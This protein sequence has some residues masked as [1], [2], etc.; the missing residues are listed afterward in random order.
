[1]KSIRSK[2]LLSYLVVLLV[3]VAVTLL[4]VSFTSR[5]AYNRQMGALGMH[6]GQELQPQPQQRAQMQFAN[7]RAA[8]FESLGYAALAAS[9]AAVLV[10]LFLSERIVLPLRAMTQASQRIAEGHYDER[11]KVS[12]DDEL[13]ELAGRFNQMAEQLEQTES[14]R[15]RLIGDVA[16]ELRTPLTTIKG[17]M[18]GLLDGV[19][20]PDQETFTQI[21][22]ESERLGRLVDDLQE[23]SR[24]EAGAYTLDKQ[25]VDAAAL[26]ATA[27]KRLQ[28][29]LDAKRIDLT[30]N[31]PTDLP[32]LLADEDRIL[33]VLTNL[34]NNALQYTP[35]KGTVNIQ[36]QK[37]AEFVQFS[38]HDT[39]AGIAPENLDLIFSRFYRVDKSRSR[40]AGSGSGIG[41]TIAKHLVEAHGGRIWVESPGL[42]QGSTFSFT[43]PQSR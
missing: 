1:M 38:V 35:T 36:A 2:L 5:L 17:S 43:I 22:E 11:V 31:L 24:V 16:H 37:N 13:A 28:R 9:L 42:G 33:Q 6:M 7:F 34:L 14:M 3:G 25:P 40:Q 8:V 41:L 4:S 30:L 15:R 29:Q 10:S 21:L 39:G 18:E 12:G 19:L 23:L 32:P 26:V 27:A 20:A